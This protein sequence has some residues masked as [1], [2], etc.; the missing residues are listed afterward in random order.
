MTEQM[1]HDPISKMMNDCTHAIGR[2]MSLCETE[3]ELFQV[4]DAVVVSA[5]TGMV[6]NGL[7]R[8]GGDIDDSR[9]ISM[10]RAVLALHYANKYA[11]DSECEAS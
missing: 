10:A 11:P 4:L 8:A 9:Q 2:V 3:E 5:L 7:K 1:L 6:M